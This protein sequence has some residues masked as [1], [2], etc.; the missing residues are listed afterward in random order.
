MD[1]EQEID[2]SL[3]LTTCNRQ[4]ELN[5]FIQSIL[6]QPCRYSIEIILI[7][8]GSPDATMQAIFAENNWKLIECGE[9]IPL[10]IARN[11]GM[12]IFRGRFLCIPDD[13]CWYAPGFIDS[14][15]EKFDQY[16]AHEAICVSVF[17]PIQNRPYGARPMNVCCKLTF[18]NV[19]QL[20]VSVGIF[21][22]TGIIK[23]YNLRFNEQ[24]GAGTFYGGGEET[25]FLCS[26]L[27]R[28]GQIVYDGS[29]RVYHEV[30]D[31]SQISLE[32]VKKYSRGYG[33][34]IG[35]ILADKRFAVLPSIFVFVIKSMSGLILKSYRKKY[36]LMYGTRLKYFFVGLFAALRS[37]EIVF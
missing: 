17:D 4:L 2:L 25:A 23:K 37:K 10:S 31:Y 7:N 19:V 24:L 28:G 27:K 36:V 26:V 30:D 35:N 20:P 5:R 9:V 29:L 11:K 1:K 12:K 21:L 18:K 8:Q 34:I 13:D 6:H 15:I 32:K 14:I 22:R 3:I 16:P 33:F